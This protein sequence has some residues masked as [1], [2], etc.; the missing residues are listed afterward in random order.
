MYKRMLLIIVLLALN[1]GCET[2]RLYV[3]V[4]DEL[5][6]P[7]LNAVVKLRTMNKVIPFGSVAS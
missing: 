4:D 2:E 5:G 6:R 1:T 3:H 7:V